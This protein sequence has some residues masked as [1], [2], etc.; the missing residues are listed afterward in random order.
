VQYVIC[1]DIADDG[2]RSRLASALL[3]FGVRIQESVFT[4]NLDQELAAAMLE[5][6]AKLIDGYWDRIH[7]FQLCQGCSP[8]TLVMGTAEIVKDGEFYII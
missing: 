1:Y 5:R 2:R 7:V 8:R 6:L 4:A 3:D